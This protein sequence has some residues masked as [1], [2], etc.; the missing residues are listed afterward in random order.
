[1]QGT[2]NS[3]S[4]LHLLHVISKSGCKGLQTRKP[5]F[6]R[7]WN[8][9]Q[10]WAQARMIHLM[11]EITLCLSCMYCQDAK[12]DGKRTWLAGQYVTAFVRSWERQPPPPNLSVPNFTKKRM[13]NCFHM[14]VSPSGCVTVRTVAWF[15]E[16]KY[17][18]PC[19]Q[20]SKL[21]E[22]DSFLV[23]RWIAPRH[24]LLK[25]LHLPIPV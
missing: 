2:S 7:A 8:R 11:W 19:W 3:N 18:L 14:W 15:H 24:S 6:N 25:T 9:G 23:C 4:V 16:T 22:T 5:V 12:E 21:T 10:R 17:S 1:M 13:M 20:V